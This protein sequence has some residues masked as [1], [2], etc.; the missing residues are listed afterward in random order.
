MVNLYVYTYGGATTTVYANG[1]ETTDTTFEEGTSIRLH[2]TPDDN[3]HYLDYLKIN[4]VTITDDDTIEGYDY[5]FLLQEDSEVVISASE[6][7]EYDLTII[8]PEGFEV[9]GEGTYMYLEPVRVELITQ[10]HAIFIGWYLD[11]V[12]MSINNPYTRSMPDF[13]VELEAR[14]DTDI[15]DDI[16]VRQFTLQNGDGDI[17]KLTSKNSEIFLNEPTNLG[18]TK[19]LGLRRIGNVEKVE[20]EKYSMPQPKGT[21]IFYK[22]SNSDKYEDYFDFV[23]FISK[24]PLKLWYR[25]VNDDEATF[26]IPVEDVS[27]DK[28]EIDR[29]GI[30]RCS[31]SF[32]G[33]G[34]WRS[35]QINEETTDQYITVQNNGD[36]QTGIEISVQRENGGLFTYPKIQFYQNNEIYGELAI[37][38]ALV[39]LTKI[40]LNTKDGEQSIKLYIGSALLPN[41]FAY[42]DFSRADGVKQFPFPKLK[43]GLTE[44]RFTYFGSTLLRD[45]TYIVNYDEEYISV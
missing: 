27:L 30:L 32:Y 24:K 6:R 7:P 22:G 14:V 42:I 39:G 12:L 40:V 34:L 18:Y 15:F 31:I 23:R 13:D 17:W 35:T 3:E 20:S 8:A 29:D 11:N 44:I 1:E 9:I 26:Y 19:V 2:S 43:Q 10:G 45:R 33:L 4:N 38:T 37:N 21:L 41:P 28:K 16:N 5:T 36:T 25:P